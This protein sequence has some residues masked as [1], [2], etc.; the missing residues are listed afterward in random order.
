MKKDRKNL[1]LH[2]QIFWNCRGRNHWSRT[3]SINHNAI[4]AKSAR[5]SPWACHH[6]SLQ[7]NSKFVKKTKKPESWLSDLRHLQKLTLDQ[8]NQQWW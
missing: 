7:I 2:D 5:T 4:A 8:R 6:Y 3:V 1:A